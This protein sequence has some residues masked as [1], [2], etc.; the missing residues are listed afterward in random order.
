MTGIASHGGIESG[1]IDRVSGA[2]DQVK[3]QLQ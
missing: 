1:A 2:V 3:Q